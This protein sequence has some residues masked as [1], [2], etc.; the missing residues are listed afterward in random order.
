MRPHQRE[1]WDS[2]RLVMIIRVR[3]RYRGMRNYAERFDYFHTIQ[4]IKKS[5]PYVLTPGLR[6]K[7]ERHTADLVE[8]MEAARA[9]WETEQRSK[10]A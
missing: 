5:R 3:I 6:E 9:E 4:T 7:H 10:P 1:A 8:M 2:G